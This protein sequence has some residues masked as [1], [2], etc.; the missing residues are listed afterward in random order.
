MK[1]LKI[2]DEKL[3]AVFLS[4]VLI[5]ATLIVFAQV[6]TRY[7]LKVPLPWSEEV[8]R[9]LFL[10]LTWVGASYATKERKHVTIDIVYEML[11][12][13]GQKVCTIISTGV[14]IAFLC[15]MVYIS[16]KLTASVASGGMIA[17]GSGIPMWVPYASI[18]TGM[19]MMLFRLLQNCVH[20]LKAA[21]QT[22]KAEKEEK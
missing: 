2:L 22:E 19:C 10:W 3:E 4:I 14:W 21:D 5:A 20:D 17:V 15:V 13:A 12:K 9:Y 8:A 7:C 6:V 11:P 1:I 18:P 16:V